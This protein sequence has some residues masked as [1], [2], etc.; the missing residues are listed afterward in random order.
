MIMDLF[1][2]TVERS[3]VRKVLATQQPKLSHL[4]SPK[5]LAALARQQAGLQGMFQ[6]LNTDRYL[7]IQRRLTPLSQSRPGDHPRPGPSRQP[8]RHAQRGRDVPATCTRAASTA[9]RSALPDRHR[10]GQAEALAE[11][12]HHFLDR[13]MHYPLAQPVRLIVGLIPRI[14]LRQIISRRLC[15]VFGACHIIPV[16]GRYQGHE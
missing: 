9:G 15:L 16:Y 4:R 6:E 14:A 7:F 3:R 13:G 5:R 8:A 10:A 2:P 12:H 1:N 11:Q